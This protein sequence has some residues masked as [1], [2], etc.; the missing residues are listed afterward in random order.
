MKPEDV[1]RIFGSEDYKI[2]ADK[3]LYFSSDRKAPGWGPF[4]GGVEGLSI[5]HPADCLTKMSRIPFIPVAKITTR[6]PVLSYL[7]I[8]YPI[9]FPKSPVYHSFYP[10]SRKPLIEARLSNGCAGSRPKL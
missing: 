3:G 9:I 2:A 5:T 6:Y 1:S 10:V 8:S 7:K 4:R